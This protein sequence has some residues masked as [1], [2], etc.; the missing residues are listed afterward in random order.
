MSIFE[1]IKGASQRHHLK[2]EAELIRKSQL[3]DDGWYLEQYPDVRASGDDPLIHYILYGESEGRLPFVFFDLNYLKEQLEGNKKT[4]SYFGHYCRYE[5]S[6]K[7]SCNYYFDTQFYLE[8]NPDLLGLTSSL[9][10]HFLHTG[11]KEGRI[12]SEQ[13]GAHEYFT[14]R[15]LPSPAVLK[16]KPSE[17]DIAERE[18]DFCKSAANYE[19]PIFL[20]EELKV[21]KVKALALYLTQFHPF[22]ENDEWWGKGFTEWTN[23]TRGRSHF[24]GHYQPHLPKHFGYYDLR[25]KEVMEEQANWAKKAGL[26][27]FCFYYYWFNGVRLMEKP[28]EML[29]SNPKVDIPFCLMW[30]NENWTRTWDGHDKEVLISQDYNESDEIPFVNDLSRH[31]S[32]ERYIRVDGRPLLFVY[33]PGIIP[34]AKET[35]QRWRD[36][37][38]LELNE[39][40]L[41]YMAQAFGDTDPREYGLDGAMEF[42][43]HKIAEGL[44]DR[45]RELVV[46][47]PEFT[48]HYPSYDDLIQKSN[49]ETSHNF[50]LIRGVAP[51]WDNEARRPGRGMGFLGSTPQKYEEWLGRVCD[52]AIQNPI[53]E[54]ESFVVINA[55][56]EWAE[57]AHLE[58]DV[59]WGAAYLNATYRALNGF[60]N[61][62]AQNSKMK[63]V[64]VGHDA[65]KHGAQ[66][67]TLNLFKTLKQKFGIDVSCVLL[68]GGPLV[69]D[70]K[71]IG[72]TY[73]ANGCQEQFANI[74]RDLNKSG[75]IQHAITSTVVTGLCVQELKEQGFSVL[76]LVHELS[77]LIA[78]YKLQENANVIA[79]MADT[80]VFASEFVKDSFEYIAGKVKGKGVIKPQGIYQTLENTT[81]AHTKLRS[82]L[83]IPEI[84]KVVVNCAYG[85]LRKGFDHFIH[86][87]KELVSKDSNYHF[88]WIG[89]LDGSLKSWVLRDIEKS[90][91]SEHVHF[92]PFLKEYSIYIEGADIFALTSR[93]D[94]FPSVVLESLSL[95]TPVVGFD[96][97]GGFV[98]IIR[99]SNNGSIVPFADI[100]AFASAIENEIA[101][102]TP[103]NKALRAKETLEKYD[104]N[105][106]SFSLLEFLKPEL[107]RVSVVVPNY[108]YEEHVA[109]RLISIFNQSY[110]IFELIVLD[111]ASTDGST[112]VIE[113]VSRQYN[114]NIELIINEKN[115]G[116]VFKQWL[117]AG[118]QASGDYLW[119]AEADDSAQVNF[120]SQLLSGDTDFSI[121]YCDS[122]QIDE[123][124]KH[125]ADNYGYYYEHD[126]ARLTRGHNVYE[127]VEV[128]KH[129]LAV[130]NQFMNVSAV[131]FETEAFNNS[132]AEVQDKLFDYRV[133]G[134]WF[135]YLN[136][137]SHS[138]SRC[139]LVGDP[140]NV[141]R[142]H[143]KSV[144]HSNLS[145]QVGE[146]QSC[147]SFAN[148]VLQHTESALKDKQSE[149]VSS[150]KK[151]ICSEECESE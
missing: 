122:V 33:R 22:K 37:F 15:K 121:A 107:K 83:G 96:E 89:E 148:K 104:W 138:N 126:M 82:K 8:S 93:E 69:D 74:V 150:I 46:H 127:G 140:L 36:I 136:I 28:L 42:P 145:V 32:D 12:A 80:V 111:D 67:L 2:K 39:E 51:S 10:E 101:A 53:S 1:R 125:L 112:S 40:P 64:L 54:N 30:A 117:K 124:G 17:N 142:R 73:V 149:Y 88:V 50:N 63:L 11:L 3:F 106:Y 19:E 113:N 120:L 99:N 61:L 21:P 48:G 5:M 27:G 35:I 24:T 100:K 47:N 143:S 123:V 94:P 59:Y 91:I 6:E 14:G 20:S 109:E 133:A 129:C 141:H 102:D 103:E 131:L 139:K 31:F 43:P 81:E 58:P 45:S 105:D 146:I 60:P 41:I 79:E 71:A 86:L 34:N 72:P 25:V 29:L 134:D 144:T 56:N 66:L 97:A 92:L 95:G 90:E 147:Q 135:L 55:W 75:D 137:L 132:I 85:D 115:S 87:A 57:G 16:V 116:S 62:T 118:E 76:S 4:L 7:L 26:H 70:Y 114:R 84:S 130:K 65:Y 110:P 151:M 49:S 23:V 44:P 128:I 18:I 78:E 68:S 119:V 108:N 13:L 9:F 38:R 77:T 52:Y 98:E